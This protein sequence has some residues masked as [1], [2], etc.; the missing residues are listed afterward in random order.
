MPH[1]F[2]ERLKD[3]L[4]VR[5]RSQAAGL[6]A[7]VYKPFRLELSPDGAVHE[8]MRVYDDPGRNQNVW[9]AMPPYYWCAAVD[10]PSPA[11][12]VLAW[13][14]SLQG[15][16]GKLPLIAYHYAGKGKVLF[17]GTDS[18]WL[19]RQ[20]VGDRFFYKFWGQGIRFVARKDET[21]SKKNWLEVRP[22]RAQPGEQA[23]IELMAFSADGSPRSESKLAVR[24]LG[25]GSVNAVE[26][27]ADPATKGRY[28]G[29]FTP[30]ATGE[31]RVLF[32]ATGGTEPVEAKIRVMAAAEELRHPNVN[33][34]TM[35]LLA[36]ISGG[37][38]VE[39]PDLATIPDRL[40]GDAR[41]TELHREATIWDN[42]L[43]LALLILLYSLDVGLRRLTGLS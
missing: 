31:Y 41:F 40:K 21:G 7:P 33:R 22:I 2:D 1:T 9:S 20:N 29:K 25:A 3:L 42:W 23:Q 36:G 17:V 43:T 26:L 30:Q 14:P 10:R 8:A 15:R 13:N 28:T 32:E 27:A 6:E 12:T 37:Q 18:T 35:E 19:W 24:V 4:P 38:L 16:F 11:A 5:L 34:P 39:L